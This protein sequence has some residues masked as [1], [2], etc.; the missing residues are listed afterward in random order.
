VEQLFTDVV[1]QSEGVAAYLVIF[2][3]LVA[4]GLGVPLPEDISLVTGGFLTYLEVA[5]LFVMMG[6]GFVGILCGDSL[7]FFFGRRFGSQVGRASGFFARVVT[8]EKRH[9]VEQLFHRHGEKIV[10]VARF[11][12]GVRAV[13]YFTAGSARMRYSRFILW[14]GI[15]AL[16]S[17]PLFV[18]LGYRFGDEL[19]RLIRAVRHGETA[20]IVGILVVALVLIVVRGIKASR[21]RRGL[22][23]ELPR[24]EPSAEAG[25]SSGD[26]EGADHSAAL[27]SG[28]ET[29]PLREKS[30]DS[31]TPV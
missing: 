21:R 28:E 6:V 17:A 18:Y 7:I 1:M 15:A 2:G 29:P 5:N 12:P 26:L 19:E 30:I 25:T 22:G 31:R 4:C 9:R 27:P 14:D 11:L 3:V 13:T 16:G 23:K 20:A 10:M 8:P 24:C